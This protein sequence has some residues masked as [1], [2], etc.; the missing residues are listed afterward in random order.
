[1]NNKPWS[2][3]VIDDERAVLEAVYDILTMEGMRVITA[4]D[5]PTGLELYQ[6]H[7][8]EIDL[9]LLDLSMPVMN[10]EQTFLALR[11]IDPDVP[12]VLSSG[13]HQQDAMRYVNQPNIGFLQKPYTWDGLVEGIRRYL[14]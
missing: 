9:V 5:G 8:A 14:E 12:V 2:I 7:Q 6:A 13:Y 1:M 11:Q 4:V 10:G 3:L